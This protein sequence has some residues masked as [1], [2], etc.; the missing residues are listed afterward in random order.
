MFVKKI[1]KM[2]PLTFAAFASTCFAEVSQT[3]CESWT[4]DSRYQVSVSGDE[5]LDLETNLTWKRCSEGQNWNGETCTGKIT[6]VTYLTAE[7]S[8][9]NSEFDWRIPS[10]LELMSL[11][12]GVY[13]VAGCSLPSINLS[14]FPD[15]GPALRRY[16]SSTKDSK[17]AKYVRV[18][19]FNN[20]A[21]FYSTASLY[22]GKI[23]LVKNHHE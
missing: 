10:I 5:V 4:P 14:I 15:G 12:A 18:V 13:K 7:Q 21:V 19:D 2:I 8:Y 11:R 22:V 16:W 6:Q 17:N 1:A 20:G 9:P 3:T 23:R